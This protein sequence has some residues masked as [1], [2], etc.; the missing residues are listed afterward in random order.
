MVLQQ[1][2]QSRQFVDF[3]TAL[4]ASRAMR[5]NPR[6]TF[7]SNLVK[8]FLIRLLLWRAICRNE[9]KLTVCMSV[10]LVNY[11]KSKDFLD[12]HFIG[13]WHPGKDSPQILYVRVLASPLR[14]FISFTINANILSYLEWRVSIKKQICANSLCSKENFQISVLNSKLV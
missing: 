2:A 12:L 5:S 9:R 10:W 3:H 13:C 14:G 11:R 1:L 7:F 8:K 4:S 6:G